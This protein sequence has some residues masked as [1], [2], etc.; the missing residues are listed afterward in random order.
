MGQ[1][2]VETCEIEG[3]K[4]ITPQVFRITSSISDARD[5]NGSCRISIRRERP[6]PASTTFQKRSSFGNATGMCRSFF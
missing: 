6:A 2:K 1:I 5:A 4:I 3:L